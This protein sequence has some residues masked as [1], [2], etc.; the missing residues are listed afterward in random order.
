MLRVIIF[1]LLMTSVVPTGV[2]KLVQ[3]WY[4]SKTCLALKIM[5][6]QC[7]VLAKPKTAF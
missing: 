5:V 3:I 4:F 7:L 1:K 2:C 6:W